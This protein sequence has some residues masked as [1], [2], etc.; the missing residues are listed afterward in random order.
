MD[1]ISFADLRSALIEPEAAAAF[2]LPARHFEG[3]AVARGVR[4]ALAAAQQ[5]YRGSDAAASRACP[6]RIRSTSR[7]STPAA[8]RS[9]MRR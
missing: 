5:P 9:S 8:W 1:T 4:Q 2:A 6:T 3:D 7:Q